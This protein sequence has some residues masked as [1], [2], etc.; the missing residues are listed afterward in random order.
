[1]EKEI[2]ISTSKYFAGNWNAKYKFFFSPRCLARALTNYGNVQDEQGQRERETDGQGDR[3][4]AYAA[5]TGKT[6]K[7]KVETI[8]MSDP[9]TQ[10]SIAFR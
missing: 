4:V 5:L 6:I 8:K 1:M 9:V 10:R 2:E 3:R 7:T